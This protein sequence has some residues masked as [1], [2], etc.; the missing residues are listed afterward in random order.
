MLVVIIGIEN[1]DPQFMSV[2]YAALQWDGRWQPYD[3]VLMIVRGM[4]IFGAFRSGRGCKSDPNVGIT[5]DLATVK[6]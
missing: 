1:G 5:L 4:I 6:G 2:T 3:L